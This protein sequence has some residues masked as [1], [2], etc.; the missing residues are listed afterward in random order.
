MSNV[1]RKSFVKSMR[2]KVIIALL[3]ACFTLF[4]A[5][6][7]SRMAF[8]EMLNTV[9]NISAPSE[10]LR[11]V[12]VISR[13][14]GT[15]DQLQRS[16]VFGNPE[17]YRKGFKESRELR[18]VLDTLSMLYAKDSVQTSRIKVIK[19]L[20]NERDKQF[21]SYLKV[22]ERLVNNKTFSDQ[23]KNINSIVSRNAE[24][25]DSTVL[26]TE[27]KTSTTTIYP[28]E[29]KSRSFFGKIFGKKRSIADESIRIV[30]EEKI[31]RDTIALSAEDKVAKSLEKSLRL[32]EDEQ[33]KKKANFL[34]REVVLANANNVL[35][36]QMLTVLRQVENEVVSQIELSGNKAEDV[37]NNGIRTMSIIMLVFLMLTGV[38]LYFILT[39][40]T[41]SGKYR[42]E[43]ELARDE[44]EYHGKAKQRFLSNMSHE[45]R[46]PLQSI[47]G[48]ADI[49]KHQEHPDH[50][51]IEA[52]HH[53]SEHLLQIVN[54]VLDYSRITSG[55][56][57]FSN[58]AFDIESLFEEVLS[59]MRPQAVSKALTLKSEFDFK[60]VRYING[61]PFRLKQ[62]LYNLLGNAIKFTESGEIV[63]SSHYKMKGNDLHFTFSVKDTG[64]GFSE[65]EQRHI[66]NEFE[67]GEQPDNAKHNS[68]GTGLGLPIIKALVENQGGRIYA[69]SKR[70]MGS[71]FTV[72]LVFT[73]AQEPAQISFN[74]SDSSTSGKIWIVDDDQLILDLCGIIFQKNDISYKIFNS[75]FK[76]LEEQ[77]D[78]EVKYVLMDIRMPDMDGVRLCQT[79]REKVGRYV[80]IFAITAQVLPDERKFLLQNGFDGLL[81]KPFREAELLSVI[82]PDETDELVVENVDFDLTALRKMTF[83]DEEQLKRILLRFEQ[84]CK[85]D[86]EQ[87]RFALSNSSLDMVSLIVHRLAG[88]IAQIGSTSL[89]SE[90][91]NCE[92][93]LLQHKK[94]LPEALKKDV[95]LLLKK[96][97]RLR[98]SIS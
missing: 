24:Q 76:L 79:L 32:I 53:S 28:T 85:G 34:N 52:I 77:W 92:M 83:N 98:Y 29:E 8:T 62:I 5:W 3:L 50:K 89:A 23:V 87:L 42:N 65:E 14:I 41:K 73:I 78:N 11:I 49:I 67:Q 80:K 54:E 71:V 55:K 59:V 97:E 38:L 31:K 86:S 96:L 15:L 18:K 39:D 72:Y 57:T 63:L 60:G 9:E 21:V 30:S 46:T 91:R 56:F 20:L 36:T 70:G 84:D 17:R 69:K 93:E 25:T 1:S 51:H 47:I 33:R 2:S 7:V 19:R 10:R 4:L 75:P 61:D 37:V 12:N 26:A 35:L 74:A 68:A 45:I 88:R 90:F 81:M 22:R 82:S 66:F 6:G 44:A 48:Y 43:L 16:Q 40:I 27:E 95:E 94:M 13:K 64:I 58:K